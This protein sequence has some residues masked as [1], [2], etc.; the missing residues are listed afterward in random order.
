[1]YCDKKKCKKE[2]CS[3]WTAMYSRDPENPDTPKEEWDCGFRWTN[4]LL[5]ELNSSIGRLITVMANKKED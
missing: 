4:I 3:F 5:S 1:M 2:K